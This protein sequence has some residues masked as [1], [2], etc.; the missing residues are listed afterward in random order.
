[1]INPFA[2]L[3]YDAIFALAYGLDAVV[4]NNWDITGDNLKKVMLHTT[5]F[6]GASGAYCLTW[7]LGCLTAGGMCA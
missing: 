6:N 3:T 2:G 4:K 1:M 7:L 5:S